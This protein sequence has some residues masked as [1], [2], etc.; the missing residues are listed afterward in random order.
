MTF[1]RIIKSKHKKINDEQVRLRS[2]Y[3]PKIQ[4]D[5]LWQK[6]TSNG[7]YYIPRA[8]PLIQRIMNAMA[9]KGKPVSDVYLDLWCRVFTPEQAFVKL[10]GLH[11]QMAFYCNFNGERA[12]HTWRGRIKILEE[13][14]FIELA[15]SAESELGYALLKNPYTVI[16]DHRK[17][18]PEKIPD[19]LYNALL[20]RTNAIGA[21]DLQEKVDESPPA[22]KVV[23]VRRRARGSTETKQPRAKKKLKSR[24]RN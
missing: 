7:W 8:F 14:G 20:E 23:R 5:D 18:N 12:V 1:P 15:A 13:L 3:W 10:G 4:D 22:K 11:E 2:E 6:S 17:A 24:V 21:D 16:R 9:P 19:R